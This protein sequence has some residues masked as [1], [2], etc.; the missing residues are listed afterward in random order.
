MFKNNIVVH[1]FTMKEL[2]YR[3]LLSAKQQPPL[4]TF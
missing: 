3:L 2:L 4:Y 1:I